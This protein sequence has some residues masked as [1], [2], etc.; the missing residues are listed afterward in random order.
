V[1]FFDPPPPPPEPPDEVFERKPWWG[2]PRNEIGVSTALRL[3]L[4]RTDEVGLAVIDAVAFSVGLSFTLAVLR[5]TPSEIE[6]PGDPLGRFALARGLQELPPDLLR[7][8][9]EFS[10]GRKAA[11]LG[12]PMLMTAEEVAEPKG[13][14]LMPGGGSGGDD[15]WESSFWL[16]PLPPAG[17][18]AFV[19]EWPAEGIALTRHEVEVEPILEAAQR[20]E[21]L[22]PPTPRDSSGVSWTDY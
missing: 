2:A 9:V 4:A 15:Y 7:F 16:W 19:V 22:W 1:S 3:V 20:A 11:T 10:D 6:R 13:P 5:R 8:G 17:P 18:L 14:F 21:T 12:M